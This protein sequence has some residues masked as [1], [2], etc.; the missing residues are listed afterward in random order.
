M[1]TL[2]VRKKVSSHWLAILI[3]T[4]ITHGEREHS[5]SLHI[6][7]KGA[8]GRTLSSTSGR[9]ELWSQL[10]HYLVAMFDWKAEIQWRASGIRMIEGRHCPIG[11]NPPTKPSPL[12]KSKQYIIII[13]E[14]AV[15][16]D[17]IV[18]RRL[19]FAAQQRIAITWSPE[20]YQKMRC[21]ITRKNQKEHGPD[22]R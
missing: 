5:S 6:W 4:C 3:D 20:Y 2:L 12:F 22:V 11:G 7:I 10:S 9:A 13:F 17:Q 8:M 15:S 21:F 16:S 18:P 19:F 14:P 1:F